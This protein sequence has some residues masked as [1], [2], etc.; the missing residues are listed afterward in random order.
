MNECTSLEIFSPRVMISQTFITQLYV[1][2]YICHIYTLK[3]LKYYIRKI[4][5]F[6]K[7]RSNCG[8]NQNVIFH[9]EGR[10]IVKCE[11]ADLKKQY[12]QLF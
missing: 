4:I 5:I 10:H 1:L 3:W 9:R 2:T 6:K 8:H 7:S 11:D 12:S